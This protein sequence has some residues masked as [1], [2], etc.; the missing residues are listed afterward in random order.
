MPNDGGNLIFSDDERTELLK[1]EPAAKK[2]I[3]PFVGAQ[4]FINGERR[5]CLWLQDISPQEL[6]TMPLSA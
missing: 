2:F 4:E 3:R 6:R 5:W 1:R